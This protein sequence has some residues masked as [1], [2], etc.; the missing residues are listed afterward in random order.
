MLE[1]ASDGTYWLNSEVVG[2]GSLRERLISVFERRGTKV[3]FVK[4]AAGLEFAE[5]AAAIDTAHGVNI[6]RVALMPR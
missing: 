3:L 6:D 1:I 5:V 2:Q 4:A